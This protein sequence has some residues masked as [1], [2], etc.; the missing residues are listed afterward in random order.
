MSETGVEE[1]QEYKPKFDY[2]HADMVTAACLII[3]G[4]LI[5]WSA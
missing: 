4:L 5:L 3:T 2:I 1:E